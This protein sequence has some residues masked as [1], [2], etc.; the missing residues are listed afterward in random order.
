VLDDE[1]DA[2]LLRLKLTLSS[3][4]AS[5]GWSFFAWAMLYADVIGD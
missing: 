5:L 4:M 2:P 3:M 1:A